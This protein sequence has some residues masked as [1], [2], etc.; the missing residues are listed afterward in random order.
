MKKLVLALILL[1]SG[2]AFAVE[3]DRSVHVSL[4][5]AEIMG[6]FNYYYDNQ[7]ECIP[8]RVRLNKNEFC[9]AYVK[10]RMIEDPISDQPEFETKRCE[11]N[12]DDQ[13]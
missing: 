7:N 11:P 13:I 10:V 9:T 3:C 5:V 2:S 1:V 6:N 4:S 8:Y 12:Q